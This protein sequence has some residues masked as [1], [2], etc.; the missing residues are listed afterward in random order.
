MKIYG[1]RE[2]CIDQIFRVH[3]KT[4]HTCLHFA[5]IQ[6]TIRVVRKSALRPALY[7]VCWFLRKA[8]NVD[9]RVVLITRGKSTGPRGPGSGSKKFQSQKSVVITTSGVKY[10][11][12]LDPDPRRSGTFLST[13]I[14]FSLKMHLFQLN[15]SIKLHELY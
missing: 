8:P 5:F 10:Q 1:P 3:A 13:Y 4:V 11:L 12:A 9:Y 2:K 15:S 14:D 6:A 7:A